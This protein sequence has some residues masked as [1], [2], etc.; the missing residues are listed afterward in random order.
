MRR[1]ANGLTALGQRNLESLAP[2]CPVVRPRFP[3]CLPWR[4]CG[5]GAYGF[6][7]A[8]NA[9]GGRWPD[10]LVCLCEYCVERPGAAEK[11]AD[12]ETEMPF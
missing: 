1:N 7:A 5:P 8:G 4:V 9:I 12:N 11:R 2:S 10:R 6:D 3:L